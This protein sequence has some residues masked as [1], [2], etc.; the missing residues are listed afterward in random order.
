MQRTWV[1]G[2]GAA[3]APRSPVTRVSPSPPPRPWPQLCRAAPEVSSTEEEG[4][5]SQ[6]TAAWVQRRE[7]GASQVGAARRVP[8]GAAAAGSLGRIQQ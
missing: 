2:N 3:A 4:E 1:C 8:R 6:L 7:G 5:A